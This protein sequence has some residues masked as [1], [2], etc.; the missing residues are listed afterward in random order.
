M[1]WDGKKRLLF[2]IQPLL[3]YECKIKKNPS[4]FVNTK[5]C[6]FCK[7]ETRTRGKAKV[8]GCPKNHDGL[9]KAM[10]SAAI[11]KLNIEMYDDKNSIVEVIV[12]DDDS[13]MKAVVRHSIEEK[14]K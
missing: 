1:I 4:N 7:A 13:S 3:H 12:L 2:L 14:E 5:D 8:H 6:G 10:K 11:L 9:R